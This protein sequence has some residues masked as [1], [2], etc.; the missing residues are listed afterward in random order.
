MA[1]KIAQH[2]CKMILLFRASQKQRSHKWITICDSKQILSLKQK[3]LSLR[4]TKAGQEQRSLK[5]NLPNKLLNELL[6]GQAEENS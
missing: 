3:S 2:I 5:R 4:Q 1:K 6:K